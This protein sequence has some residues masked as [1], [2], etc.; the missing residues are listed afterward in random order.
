MNARLYE[1]LLNAL[2][3][4]LQVCFK[5]KVLSFLNLILFPIYLILLQLILILI[6]LNL[7][8]EGATFCVILASAN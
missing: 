5:N 1:I 4:F 8:E 6:S 2:P 7:T 3:D